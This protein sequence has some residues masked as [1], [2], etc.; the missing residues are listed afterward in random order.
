M[1]IIAMYQVSISYERVNNPST[2]TVHKAAPNTKPL[3]KPKAVLNGPTL[4][5]TKR[6][7][8]VLMAKRPALN[9]LGSPVFPIILH[10]RLL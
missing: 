5:P 8:P 7:T 1:Q 6:E 2:K 9:L 4:K 3:L 10:S